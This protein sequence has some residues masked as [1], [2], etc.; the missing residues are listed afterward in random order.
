M[1]TKPTPPPPKFSR[2]LPAPAPADRPAYLD[3]LS[4]CGYPLD[5]VVI[6]FETFF[7]TEYS[8]RKMSTVE[9]VN[10]E[11]FEILGC[12]IF[13][14]PAA[15]R[16]KDPWTQTN[17]HD[18][19][20]ATTQAFRSLQSV[21]GADLE[22]C[23]VVAHNAAF[24]SIVLAHKLGIWPRYFIDTLGLA[25][26]W[27]ARSRN[28]LKHLAERLNLPTPKGD[29]SKYKG[30]TNRVRFMRTNGRGLKLP[31]QLPVMTEAERADLGAYACTDAALEYLA[32][33]QLLPRLSTPA[34]ELRAIQH[35]I[36]SF[37]K[38]CF[39]LDYTEAERIKRAM[40]QEMQQAIDK[41]NL[42]RTQAG[43]KW[44][45]RETIS[46]ERSFEAELQASL[47]AAGSDPMAYTKPA[48]NKKGWK[49]AIAQ[50]DAA[51]GRL[52]RHD[53][54]AVR[55]LIEARLAVK[56]WPNHVSRIDNLVAQAKAGGDR[57]GV[58]LRY[59]GAH[60]GRWSGAEK[61]NLQNLGSR[62]H[63]LINAIRTL[64]L[65]APGYKMVIADASQI[66]A[67]VL[68]WIA[69]QWDLVEKFANNEEIYCGFATK[70]LGWPVRK[71]RDG[72]IPAIEARHKWGR[73]AIGKVGVL[74]CGYGMGAA[75]TVAFAKGAFDFET[76][77]KI[78]KTYRED[79]SLIVQFW[80]DI[81][82][83]FS[84]TARYKKPCSMPRGLRFHSEPDC[85]VVMTLPSGRRLHYHNVRVGEGSWGPELLL[86]N[87]K[88]KT[89][90]RIWGGFL[91]ENCVQAMSRDILWSAICGMEDAGY[92]TPFHVHDELVA[93]VPA[94]QADAALA[95]AIEL[96]STRPEWGAELPLAAEGTVSDRYGGH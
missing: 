61:L 57:L 88:T 9:F 67:R 24:E 21:Y 85:D 42:Y 77:Q 56:S 20:E 43:T 6:D 95:H 35:T 89:W 36:E 34:T 68:A 39:H 87:P 18:G 63:D 27:N 3:V 93:H 17:W 23:T 84:Y 66:E 94:E 75:A 5:I 70:V 47:A 62:G 60:T 41:A 52:Q 46:G 31:V 64:I 12:S 10:H 1:R 29:T 14:D 54:P 80:G 53:D 65:A 38:P 45:T 92:R 73:N 55:S 78:V 25:R 91:T 79:N 51:L 40:G 82:K 72:G 8:L 33:V 7:S 32:F 22:R 81:E 86:G 2:R 37:S 30:W 13:T 49:F 19:E 90:E 16:G 50:T 26:H 74:G 96:L 15:R 48:K 69:G 71:P 58:P 4:A 76:A 28:D 11:D 59:H 83:A 44:V